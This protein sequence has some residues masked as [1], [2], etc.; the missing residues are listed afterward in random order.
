M[1]SHAVITAAIVA[2][3]ARMAA[4]SCSGKCADINTNVC[5]SGF[6]KGLCPGAANIQCCTGKLCHGKCA[7]TDEYTC[8]T[9]FATD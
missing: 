9:G 8:S 6:V 3:A 7:N 5:S 4:A 2:L 1:R